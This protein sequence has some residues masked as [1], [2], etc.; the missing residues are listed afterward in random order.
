MLIRFSEDKV[1]AVGGNGTI[2][3]KQ[4]ITDV[5][6]KA[7]DN[8]IPEKF[9]LFQNYPNPFNPSTTINFYVPNTSFVNLKVYNVLGNELATLVNG[10]KPAGNYEVQFDATEIS[11]GIYFYKLQAGSFSNTRKMALLK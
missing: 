5:D 2:I 6:G 1:W 11:S 9:I 8:T 3:H 4:L 10:E 7:L